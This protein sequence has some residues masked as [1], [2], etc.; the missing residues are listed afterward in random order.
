MLGLYQ[1]SRTARRRLI[2]FAMGAVGVPSRLLAPLLGPP[3]AY[4]AWSSQAPAAP[5]QLT[6]PRLTAICGHLSGPPQ[7]LFGVVGSDVT[8]SLSPELHG[9][10][11]AAADL[12]YLMIPVS[13]PDPDEL[14]LIF[15]PAGETPFDR[16][17]LPAGGWAVTTPYKA[18]A[19]A[20]A[21]VAAPRVRRC[22]AA[23]TLVLRPRAIFADT[24]DADGVV[25]VLTTAG[26]D[27]PGATAVVQGTGGAGRSAAVG[28]D[29]AGVDVRLRGRDDGRTRE[30]AE[31][32]GVGWLAAGDAPP[33]GSIL[34]N[35]TPLGSSPDDPLPFT[36]REVGRAI[37]VVDMVYGS[38]HAAAWR[39][40]PPPGTSTAG[41]S[42]LPGLRP[43]RGVHRSAAAQGG[44]A[45]R[46][47]RCTLNVARSALPPCAQPCPAKRVVRACHS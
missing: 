44:D 26:F 8:G 34:V 36:E 45:R 3:I 37:V 27:L 28:L 39:D 15:T 25:G 46:V 24:T 1:R 18:A 2:A 12:P 32:I 29:L 33:A 5:G 16:V 4:C 38:A 30:V 10:G 21:T 11:Y 13:V 19:A 17:G 14:E 40:R 41:Q 43:V 9:A 31:A 47:A 23:N 35:A 7:R 20:A 22:G 42:G 6:A